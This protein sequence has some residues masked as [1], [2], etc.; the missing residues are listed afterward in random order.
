MGKAL[1]IHRPYFSSDVTR[2]M[3]A[4]QAD[5]AHNAAFA[6]ARRWLQD[7]FVSQ[8]LIDRMFSLPSTRAYW[9]TVEDVQQLGSRAPWYEEW[10]LARCP[11]YLKVMDRAD[12][13][14]MLL[15]GNLA[16]AT[17]NSAAYSKGIRSQPE[18][19]GIFLDQIA[20]EKR[21]V[22]GEQENVLLRMKWSKAPTGPD[23]RLPRVLQN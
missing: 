7:Q 10:L 13:R 11:D 2:Q 19:M 23:L 8:A 20:C 16:S 9:L 6:K 18:T 15:S 3:S 12:V 4:A 5:T 21:A 17:T 22:S 1:A 14:Q